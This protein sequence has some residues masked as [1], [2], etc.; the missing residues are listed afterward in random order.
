MKRSEIRPEKMDSSVWKISVPDGTLFVTLSEYQK[1]PWELRLTLGKSGSTLYAW[2]FALERIISLAL[3]Y[4]VPIDEIIAE[5]SGLTSDKAQ[6]HLKRITIRS[7]PEGIA[8]A[9]NQYLK[10][11]EIKKSE[12]SHTHEHPILE[13]D[14]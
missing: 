9:L 5:L 13:F 3:Q 12:S 6:K 8:Y 7:G 1:K 11:Q 10:E 2:I 4:E 14:E